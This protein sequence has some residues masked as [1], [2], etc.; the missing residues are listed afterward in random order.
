MQSFYQFSPQVPYRGRDRGRDRFDSQQFIFIL[1]TVTCF[2][3]FCSSLTAESIVFTK[4]NLSVTGPGEVRA[5]SEDRI[6]VFCH[7]PHGGRTDAPLWNRRESTAAY[8]PYNSPTLK[9]QVGQPT[10][11]S[12][13]CLGCH[14]GTIALGDLLSEDSIIPVGGGDLMPPGPGLI[15]TDL[16]D[17][18]PISFDYF[19]S[20][21]QAGGELTQP[22]AWDP[23]VRLDDQSQLQCTTC[24][25]PHDDQ[26]GDFLVIENRDA[27]LCRQCHNLPFFTQTPHADSILTWNGMGVDPWPHTDYTDVRTNACMNCHRSHHAGGMVELL[28]DAR[29]EEVCF[30]CHNGNVSRFNLQAVF[31]KFSAHPLDQFQG[32]HQAGE[33]PLEASDHVECTDCHN[34]HRASRSP[35]QPPFVKGVL[36]GVSGIDATGAPLDE[37]VYEYQVCFKCHAQ[38]GT[39]PLGAI[40]RQIDSFNTLKEFSPSSP[41]FHPVETAG[42][43]PDVPSLISPLTPAS[44]IYCSDCHGNNGASGGVVGSKGPHGSDFEFLL[45][46]EY[47]TGDDISESAT[48]YA[49]CYQCHSQA[50]ILA[51]QSFP[52]HFEHIVERRTPCSVCHDAHGIDFG[53]GNAIN[54]AHLINFDLSVVETDP[55]STR[56]EYRSLAP[57]SGECYLR[58]HGVDHS[59]KVY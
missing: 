5:L 53:R 8:I 47:R 43:N 22:A 49:L 9:A 57:R 21:A 48:A 42:R 56:L 50:S 27:A 38:E 39:P 37:A 16:R 15:G 31:Q 33:T 25:D 2:L 54:N 28:S 23:H 55:T 12:K 40:E 24:H 26:W 59:P 3:L 7:T 10:G 41:S 29:E 30:T 14:D 17:D 11:A 19:A 34:P 1:V 52:K 44:L 20:L 32:A 35:A 36:E 13:L 18:H 4:H 46:R 6:C 58:C 45:V 51:N